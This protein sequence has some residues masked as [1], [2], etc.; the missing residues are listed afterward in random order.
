[1]P[2]VELPCGTETEDGSESEN[3]PAVGAVLHATPLGENAVGAIFVG[4]A[5]AVKPI[6]LTLLPRA[7]R[8]GV[9]SDSSSFDFP[10]P[11]M[12]PQKLVCRPGLSDTGLKM[13]IMHI[14]V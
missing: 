9:I 6:P 12:D 13:L 8:S 2:P 4:P 3:V 11:V 14:L 10:D 7:G 1:V 5:L